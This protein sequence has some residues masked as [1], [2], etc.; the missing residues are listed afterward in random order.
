LHRNAV[1]RDG[2]A[3]AS[4]LGHCGP[5]Q[6]RKL[7]ARRACDSF[8]AVLVGAILVTATQIE[9]TLRQQIVWTR[10][11]VSMSSREIHAVE[12]ATASPT[13]H[14]ATSNCTNDASKPWIRYQYMYN[15]DHACPPWLKSVQHTSPFFANHQMNDD[16]ALH[17]RPPV[18]AA[19][20]ARHSNGPNGS[21]EPADLSK[22]H[23]KQH[24]ATA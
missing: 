15:F 7:R 17:V 23:H 14:N 24:Q 1:C 16:P 12:T 9:P 22:H 8:Q 11:A 13:T 6:P 4:S 2:P 18:S 5:E 3:T 10:S 19:A 21:H 20:S